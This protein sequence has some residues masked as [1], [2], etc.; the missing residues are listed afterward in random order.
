MSL[1]AGRRI[2]VTGGHG[3]LGSRIAESLRQRGAVVAT[4]SRSDGH[5]LR[6]PDDALRAF[7]KWRPETVFNCAAN[8]GGIQY[9]RIYPATIMVDNMLMGIHTMEAARAAGAAK[10][11]NIVA[12]CAYPGYQEDGLL[13]EDHFWDGPLHDS[14]LNY[15]ITKKVQTV[16][17]LMYKRQ[18]GFNSIHLVMTNLYGPGEHFDPDRS[19]ALAAL[20]RKFYEA[21]RDSNA[22]VVVWGTGRPVREWMYVDDAASAVIRAAEVYEDVAP[23]N[24]GMGEGSTITQL[25]ETI[26]DVVGYRGRIVYDTSKGDGAMR[27]VMDV[28]AMKKALGWSSSVTLEEGIRRTLQ[29]F[30]DHYEEATHAEPAVG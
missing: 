4:V 28:A 5:D 23:L 21:K 7:E 29:W 9:Q 11:V 2:A 8:Q 27:K 13:S 22:E 12:A 15:G 16:Q 19:H 18:F 30:I 6:R 20:I 25:A 24:I 3:F 26:R 17:G 1:W 10:Y 14:V